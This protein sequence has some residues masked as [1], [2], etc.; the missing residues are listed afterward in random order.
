MLGLSKRTEY[1]L[2]ALAYL[3]ERPDNC[4]PAREIAAAYNLPQALLMNL[5]KEMHGAGLLRST[6]GTKGGYRIAV[7]LDETSLY[8][9]IQVIDGPVELVECVNEKTC[10]NS[11]EHCRISTMCPIQQPLRALHEK[12]IRFLKDVKIS[13][14]VVPGRRI[15][16]PVELV[17]VGADTSGSL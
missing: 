1:A 7:N 13:D 6:R 12:L 14:L 4:C 11:L 8:D 9:L 3:V 2:I 5:L 16:V 17:G 10:C 15:D